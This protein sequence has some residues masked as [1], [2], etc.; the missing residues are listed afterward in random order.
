MRMGLFVIGIILFLVF[1]FIDVGSHIAISMVG[2][3]AE[4]VISHAT[5]NLIGV[6]LAIIGTI[7]IIMSMVRR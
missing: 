6:A 7:F 5:L 4:D 3:P 2:L 1:L